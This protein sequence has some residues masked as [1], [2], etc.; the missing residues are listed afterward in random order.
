MNID[1]LI[2]EIVQALEVG[3]HEISIDSDSSS[4]EAWDSLGHISILARLDS[5]FEDITERVPELASALS[6]REI[7]KL[8]NDIGL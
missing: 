2:K 1:V 8:L 5:V 6:V 7:H 4:V 3:E